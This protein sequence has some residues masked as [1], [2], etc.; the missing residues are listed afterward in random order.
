MVRGDRVPVIRGP[1]SVRP[2]LRGA[3]R[4]SCYLDLPRSGSWHVPPPLLQRH[5]GLG[6]GG[7]REL[8]RPGGRAARSSMGMVEAHETWRMHS[9]RSA[10][11][12][13][14]RWPISS[15][16]AVA[17]WN[18][19]GRWGVRLPHQPAD[20]PHTLP[21]PHTDPKFRALPSASC[22]SSLLGLV[23]VMS[24]ACAPR[25]C[26]TGAAPGGVP[27]GGTA[28]SAS[29]ILRGL[30]PIGAGAGV[31]QRRARDGMRGRG[32]CAASSSRRCAGCGS[33]ETACSS[34]GVVAFVGFVGKALHHGR[35]ALPSGEA[36]AQEGSE[37]AG[38]QPRRRGGAPAA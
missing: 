11:M 32:F 26:G 3:G 24:A 14:Y 34:V 8:Q 19:V 12:E 25:R 37:A 13:A 9:T 28:A 38:M 17:F 27:R 29:M 2:D 30:L 16:V 6:D 35:G 36:R 7:R 22:Q 5:A 4:R 10:W 20:R 31:G 15:F 1:G 23:L 21:G 18:F 33:S